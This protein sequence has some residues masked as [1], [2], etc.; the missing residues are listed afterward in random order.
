M[1][2]FRR[3]EGRQVLALPVESIRPNPNQPRTVFRPEELAG[4]ADSI[5]QV[6]I[7]Q[8]LSVRRT[9]DEGVAIPKNGAPEGGGAGGLLR[10]GAVHFDHRAPISSL[11]RAGQHCAAWRAVY[12]SSRI[13]GK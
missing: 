10:P 9:A 3:N 12:F 6:G 5:A 1:P 11:G 13:S 2:L 4:L 8:P 7:L